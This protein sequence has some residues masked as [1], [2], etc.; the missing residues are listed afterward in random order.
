MQ[1]KVRNVRHASDEEIEAGSV[2]FD[3]FDIAN[4]MAPPERLQ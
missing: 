2:G 4:V 3:A 1:L